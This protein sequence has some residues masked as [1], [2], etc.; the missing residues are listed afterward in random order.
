[1]RRGAR[2]QGRGWRE[3]DDDDAGSCR[4]RRRVRGTAAP[5]PTMPVRRAST[6]RVEDAGSDGSRPATSPGSNRASRIASAIVAKRRRVPS[7]PGSQLS[8][9]CCPAP[10]DLP[11]AAALIPRVQ[12]HHAP[13]LAVA[14]WRA[15]GRRA[16]DGSE[17]GRCRPKVPQARLVRSP[18]AAPDLPISRL[19][20]LY[21]GLGG[22]RAL[23][24]GNRC[25]SG[26]LPGQG[27]S[28]ATPC[29]VQASR[30][31]LGISVK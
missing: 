24:A 21:R 2:R 20:V 13:A 11:R 7:S 12:S 23:A 3:P 17:S 18:T 4:R 14:S 5:I 1:M 15:F 8:D 16:N 25:A 30:G 19:V 26:H 31:L 22:H 6:S 28:L 9:I 27:I 29:W 10:T